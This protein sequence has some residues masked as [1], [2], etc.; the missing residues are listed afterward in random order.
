MPRKRSEARQV[1]LREVSSRESD[2]TP[3]KQRAGV[4]AHR[5]GLQPAQQR[6]HQPP[7]IVADAVDG[8]IDHAH[9]DAAPQAFPA[10][11]RAIGCTMAAS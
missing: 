10:T 5:A 1:H 7:T 6:T 2:T 3:M 4:G 9:V 8:A 11:R